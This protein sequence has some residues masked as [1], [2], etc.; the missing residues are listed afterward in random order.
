MFKSNYSAH[1]LAEWWSSLKLTPGE[2]T[3]FDDALFHVKVPIAYLKDK[4]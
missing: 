2:P 4:N 1:N 3:N